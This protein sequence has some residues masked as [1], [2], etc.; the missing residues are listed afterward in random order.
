M[1]LFMNAFIYLAYKCFCGWRISPSVSFIFRLLFFSIIFSSVLARQF[2]AQF[3]VVALV[4]V[5]ALVLGLVA[6][7]LG[8][9]FIFVLASNAED[10]KMLLFVFFCNF[11]LVFILFNEL[12]DVLFINEFILLWKLIFLSIFEFF[13][14]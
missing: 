6:E 9:A 7:I 3:I 14:G 13:T 2:V 12:I 5:L 10:W 8:L 4:L 1:C 11:I